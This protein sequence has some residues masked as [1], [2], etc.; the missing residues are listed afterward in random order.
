LVTLLLT[1]FP[2]NINKIGFGAGIVYAIAK[3]MQSRKN[4]NTLPIANP[5]VRSASS[6]S[7]AEAAKA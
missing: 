1:L 5:I 4:K 2:T 6:H 7:E 3:S